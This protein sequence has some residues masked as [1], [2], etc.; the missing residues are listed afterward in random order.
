M[1][2]IWLIS[3]IC[4]FILFWL[5]GDLI[6]FLTFICVVGTF[7]ILKGFRRYTFIYLEIIGLGI[8]IILV[9]ACVLF[10]ALRTL[11]VLVIILG[12]WFEIAVFRFRRF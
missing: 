10:P 3:L 12:V 7:I 9:L 8:Y 4:C 6:L 5:F 11:K 2:L 1:G